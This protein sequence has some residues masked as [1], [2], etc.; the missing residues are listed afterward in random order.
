[1]ARIPGLRLF[2]LH[3]PLAIVAPAAAHGLRMAVNL[4]VIKMI[5]L[6]LGP[7]GLGAIGNL[8]S[9]LS[10][11]MVFAGGGITNGITKYV[12]EY[13]RV[14]RPTIRIIETATAIGFSVSAGVAILSIAAARPIAQTLFGDADL[15]WLSVALGITHLACF[16]GSATLAVANG[17]QRSDI[18]A[19]VSI[20]AYVACIP[21]AYALIWQ[22]G[23]SGA[24]LALMV[25][26]GCTAGPAAWLLFRSPLRDVVKIRFH[27][28]EAL[29]LMRFAAM[30]LTSAVTFPLAE[31]FV[32]SIVN[33]ELGTATAGL[34]QAS[35]R[36]SGAVIGFFTVYL[37]VSY[38]PR[39]SST[40]DPVAACALVVR[41]LAIV[42]VSFS[43]AALLLHALRRIIIPLLLSRDFAPLETVIG[44]QLLG[45]L[46]RVCAYTVGF[47]AIAKARLSLHIA[48][49]IGQYGIYAGLSAWVI[50]HGGTLAQIVQAYSA[51]YFLYFLLCLTGLAIYRYRNR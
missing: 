50:L 19:L 38:M 21:V 3:L 39:L 15:W 12:A 2:Q 17:Q 13:R 33:A 24:A 8:M 40:R 9:L 32:R 1:M 18:F 49:E 23:F 31:T 46:F 5:A 28:V 29:Q 22:G 10:V 27:R 48:A 41:T 4:L 43:V 26:A 42:A 11:I 25:M 47:L 35:I 34:W 44:W 36:L 6:R 20:I 7:T 37:A 30:T 14:A 51:S 45:D 16:V